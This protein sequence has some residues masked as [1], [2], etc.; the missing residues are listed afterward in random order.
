MNLT[1]GQLK[2][3]RTKGDLILLKENKYVWNVSSKKTMLL[4]KEGMESCDKE[5][6]ES[7]LVSMGL[8]EK[9]AYRAENKK[10]NEEMDLL[11]EY[12]RELLME[13]NFL[14][15]KEMRCNSNLEL[16]I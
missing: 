16:R 6:Q 3:F 4:D 13:K 10:V 7:F 9:E 15:Q 8:M 12:M 11:R 2:A 14:T 1:R 5:S